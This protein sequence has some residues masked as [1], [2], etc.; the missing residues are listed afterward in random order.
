M[1]VCASKNY[2]EMKKY[3]LVSIR[4]IERDEDGTTSTVTEKFIVH[5]TNYTDAE[6]QAYE[7]AEQY[8]SGQFR[9]MQVSRQNVLDSFGLKEKDEGHVYKIKFEYQ[10][11]IDGRVNKI[12]KFTEHYYVVAKNIKSAIDILYEKLMVNGE[13]MSNEV[14]QIQKLIISDFIESDMG[15]DS[16]EE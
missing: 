5:A 4:H 8:W 13:I 9:I 2:R 10:S 3:F 14:T 15:V 6:S 11:E 16:E 1:Y 12:M 7:Y